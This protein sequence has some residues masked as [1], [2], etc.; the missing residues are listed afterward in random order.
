MPRP[1]PS[2]DAAGPTGLPRG[3]KPAATPISPLPIA[4]SRRPAPVHA[5]AAMHVLDGWAHHTPTS[6]AQGGNWLTSATSG[7]DA[8]Q[9]LPS[10]KSKFGPFL[11]QLAILGPVFGFLVYFV[12]GVPNFVACALGPQ[13]L[14]P[15]LYLRL[16]PGHEGGGLRDQKTKTEAKTQANI[17]NAPPPP[18]SCL[19]V[20][21]S[22]LPEKL[23]L[24]SGAER[25][26][27]EL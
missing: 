24:A 27:R 18:G 2:P 25:H 19:P 12:H 11:S 10:C 23:F 3:A 5:A 15:C 14:T 22:N 17:V 16:W 1:S 6:C 8:C 13:R 9:C 21:G 26:L 4:S 7:G 20:V